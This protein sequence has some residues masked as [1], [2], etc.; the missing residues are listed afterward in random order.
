[1]IEDAFPDNQDKNTYIG[2]AIQRI[3]KTNKK[4]NQR[5]ILE[6]SSSGKNIKQFFKL[7]MIADIDNEDIHVIA[8][9]F[10]K[11]ESVKEDST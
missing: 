4:P 3:L 6:V 10:C 2:K 8:D 9:I 5:E 11:N 7:K 1:M